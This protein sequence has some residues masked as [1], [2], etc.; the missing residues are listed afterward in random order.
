MRWGGCGGARTRARWRKRRRASETLRAI[1]TADDHFAHFTPDN[2]PPF[3]ACYNDVR[4][5]QLTG[6]PLA[7]LAILGRDPDEA[8]DRLAAAAAGHT[9]NTRARAVC[10]TKLASLTMATDDPVHAAAIGAAA[11]DTAATLRSRGATDALRELARYAAEHQH[12][13]EVAHLRHRIAT[14]V[15]TDRP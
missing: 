14:L 5:A 6:Q 7:D 13:D 10:L 12:L 4:H 9:D 3:L 15:C 1:G 2:E 11:L 8:T